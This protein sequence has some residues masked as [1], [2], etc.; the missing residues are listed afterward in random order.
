MYFELLCADFHNLLFI[1]QHPKTTL[2]FFLLSH[3]L[4]LEFPSQTG[5][6][7]Q[8]SPLLHG[9]LQPVLLIGSRC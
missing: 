4:F 8:D 7:F 5:E 3:T 6:R 2:K 1:Q 9:T